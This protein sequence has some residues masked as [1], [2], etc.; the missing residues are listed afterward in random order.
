MMVAKS[1]QGPSGPRESLAPLGLLIQSMEEEVAFQALLN[2]F[3]L[4]GTLLVPLRIS[5]SRHIG[6][7]MWRSTQAG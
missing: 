6:K 1:W 7:H 5:E 3:F 4:L 2:A